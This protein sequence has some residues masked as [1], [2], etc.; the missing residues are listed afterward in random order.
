MSDTNLI[1]GSRDDLVVDASRC[2]KMRFNE[3]SC[4]RCVDICPHNAVSLDGFIA[5]NPNH[6]SGCLLCTVV[7]PVGALEQNNDFFNTSAQLS[8]VPEPILGCIRTK[9]QSNATLACLGGLSEEHLLTLCHSL[10]GNLTLNLTACRDCPNNDIIPALQ[11]RLKELAESGLLGC[12]NLV[13]ADTAQDIHFRDE[14]VDRRSFFKS[15]RGSLFHSAALLISTNEQTKQFTGYAKKRIPEK[16]ECL[17]ITVM[18]LP[19]ELASLVRARFEQMIVF[20]NTCTTCQSCVA[21]CPTGAL[22][23]D[24]TD[25]HPHFDPQRCTGCGLCVE[26]C[27]EG[28][29]KFA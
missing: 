8:R 26:F 23:T 27:P 6:C 29:L 17:N 16:R 12:C 5:I 10:S 24:S 22:L 21:I 11:Q 18:R 14:S 1:N 13:I 25:T 19:P 15:L 3:S 9:E 20:C 2:L 7:C 28:A 4:H